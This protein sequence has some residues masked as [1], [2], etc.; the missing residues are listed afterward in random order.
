MKGSQWGTPGAPFIQS[1]GVGCISQGKHHD[2]FYQKTFAKIVSFAYIVVP[3][4]PAHPQDPSSLVI[5]WCQPSLR[6]KF[7]TGSSPPVQNYGTGNVIIFNIIL[8]YWTHENMLAFATLV[9][10]IPSNVGQSKC[11]V[12]MLNKWQYYM[13]LGLLL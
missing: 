6:H 7:R 2:S 13:N 8:S 3:S 5:F 11:S 4:T 9:S 1:K 12:N 10:S